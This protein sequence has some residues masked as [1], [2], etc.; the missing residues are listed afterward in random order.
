MERGT[1]REDAEDTEKTGIE[2]SALFASVLRKL[3]V[4]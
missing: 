3:R 4:I 2:F 1:R